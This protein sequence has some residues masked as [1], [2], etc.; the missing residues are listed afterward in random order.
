M[1]STPGPSSRPPPSLYLGTFTIAFASLALEVALT[2]LLSVVT[3]YHL[4]F[5]AISAAMLGL[6]FLTDYSDYFPLLF[7]ILSMQI[8]ERFAPRITAATAAPVDPV[9]ELMV[10]PAP[11]SKKR[12]SMV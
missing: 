4:A 6:L 9:P 5:F 3:W 1:P 12:T 7:G 8:A 11:R 2:R 10:S